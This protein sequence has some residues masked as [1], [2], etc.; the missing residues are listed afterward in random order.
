MAQGDV[1]AYNIAAFFA[2]LFL[3]EFG[4]DKF[5]HHTAIVVRHTGISE[6]IIGLLPAGGEWEELLVVVA[7]LVR[8]RSSLALGN[9]IGAARIYSILLLVLTTFVTPITYFS[10]E[11]IWLACGAL[12]IA[13]FGGHIIS[14][15]FVISRK[16]LTVPEA[17]DGDSSEDDSS[18][19]RSTADVIKQRS[20]SLDQIEI[21][22]NGTAPT[23]PDVEIHLTS[24]AVPELLAALIPAAAP[25]PPATNITDP[26]GISDV[27]FGIIILAIV[28][29]LPEKFVTIMSSSRGYTGILVANTAGSNIFLLT[30]YARIIL[31]DTKGTLDGGNVT[32]PKLAVSWAST[33]GF[34]LTV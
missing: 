30:L 17:S 5:I 22:P 4:A 6:T 9:I 20:I 26:F 14:M 27:L 11:T 29:T 13:I 21:L 15:G 12:L 23:K 10:R 1:V 2:T 3:L 8:G 28:T 34:V 19:G 7:S 24:N 31:V 32:I 16:I 18:D 25:P 33:L